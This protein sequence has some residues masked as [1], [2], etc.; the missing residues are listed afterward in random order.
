MEFGKYCMLMYH[1]HVLLFEDEINSTIFLFYLPY[2]AVSLQLYFLFFI[3][4]YKL[5]FMGG[6]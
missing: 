2:F 1:V 4:S 3:D 5:F 6:C